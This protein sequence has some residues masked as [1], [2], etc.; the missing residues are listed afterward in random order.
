[1]VAETEK[2]VDACLDVAG[3]GGLGVEV[4]D[5]LTADGILLVVEGEENLSC[6]GETLGGSIPGEKGVPNKENEGHEGSEL[7]C[8]AVGGALRVF[9]GSE[10][11]VEPNGDQVGYMVG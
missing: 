5:S 1:M 4:G 6:P 7:D 9:T 3:C 2:D 10:A 11:E 8:P